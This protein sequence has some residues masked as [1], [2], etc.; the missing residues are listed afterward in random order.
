MSITPSRNAASLVS[1]Q[2]VYSEANRA[3]SLGLGVN[4]ALVVAKLGG[5]LLTGSASLLADA[6]N[7]VGDVASA[8]A[9]RGALHVAQKEEDDDHP[10][11]HSKAESIAGLSVSLVVVVGA[12]LLA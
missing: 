11:G 1:R 2:N 3:A 12:G 8:L 9:V 6:F 5:V 4:A 10:Y 7:S